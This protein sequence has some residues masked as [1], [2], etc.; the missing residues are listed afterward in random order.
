MCCWTFLLASCLDLLIMWNLH[1]FHA[2]G[3]QTSYRTCFAAAV[4]AALSLWPAA[5]AAQSIALGEQ[6]S[7]HILIPLLL[8]PSWPCRFPRGLCWSFLGVPVPPYPCSGCQLAKSGLWLTWWGWLSFAACTAHSVMRHWKDS[9]GRDSWAYWHLESSWIPS[10]DRTFRVGLQM[11]HRCCWYCLGS[12]RWWISNG[13]EPTQ[14]D[15]HVYYMY[16][17]KNSFPEDNLESVLEDSPWPWLTCSSSWAR[18]DSLK[19]HCVCLD[20]DILPPSCMYFWQLYVAR[21]IPYLLLAFRRLLVFYRQLLFALSLVPDPWLS[22][23]SYSN[24]S[25]WCCY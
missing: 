15:H 22:H 23:P 6:S 18:A 19:F 11:C 21:P 3:R 9:L 5:W 17:S 14:W 1:R 24:C 8:L 4:L 12:P 10:L 7:F 13:S 20:S 16:L 2:Q 25:E